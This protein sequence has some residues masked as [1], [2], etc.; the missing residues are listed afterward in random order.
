M[1]IILNVCYNGSKYSIGGVALPELI[2]KALY[3]LI[4][5]FS[6]FFLISPKAHQMLYRAVTGYDFSDN[7]LSLGIHIGC[8]LALLMN[9]NKRIRYLRSEKRLMRYG[10]RRHGRQ[11]DAVALLDIRILNTAV[12]PLLIA[13]ILLRNAPVW[14]ND[15]IWVAMMLLLYGVVLFLPRLLPSGNKNGRSFSRLDCILMGFGGGLGVIPGF[16][17]MG[18]MY[19]LSVARGADKN[20]AFDLSL[21][22]TIP[23][24][25]AML[26]FDVFGCFAA[27]SAITGL[28]FLG[29]LIAALTS[30]CGAKMALNLIRYVCNRSN[31]VAFA[32]YSW[33]VAIFLLLIYLFVA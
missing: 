4:S 10:K 31:T 9:C 20:Y 13:F 25:S 16:S 11:P 18:S 29:G 6:E 12:V 32:Y 22:L 3:A 19:S 21:L 27:A 15:P 26:C 28:Q 8:L 7:L 2:H 23:M 24:V 17:G 1:E 33:G 14:I 5:G 30:F